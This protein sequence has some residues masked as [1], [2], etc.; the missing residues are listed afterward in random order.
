MDGRIKWYDEKK[1]YGFVVT[2]EREDIY[3]HKTGVDDYG[4][5]GL[6]KDDPVTFQVRESH[7]GKQA[8]HLKPKKS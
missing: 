8:V 5:F 7:R 4:Y 3:V 2:D 1:G 6:K